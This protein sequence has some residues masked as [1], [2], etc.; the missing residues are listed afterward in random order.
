MGIFRQ[1]VNGKPSSSPEKMSRLIFAC[2]S[3]LLLGILVDQAQ[4]F[5]PGMKSQFGGKR[6]AMLRRIQDVAAED[7]AL[8]DYACDTTSRDFASRDISCGQ[9]KRVVRLVKRVLRARK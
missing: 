3:V 7:H 4:C 8:C 2:L 5:G 1:G 6:S 9:C